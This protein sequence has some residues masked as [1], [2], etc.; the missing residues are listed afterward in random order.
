[1][2]QFVADL[3]KFLKNQATIPQLKHLI[4]SLS[5]KICKPWVNWLL[6]LVLISVF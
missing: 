1:M 2:V 6:I 3:L 5:L 4:S